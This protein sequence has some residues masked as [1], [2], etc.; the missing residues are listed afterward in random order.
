MTLKKPSFG[1]DIPLKIKFNKHII[2]LGYIEGL[3]YFIDALRRESDAPIVICD[4]KKNIESLKIII[5]K[6]DYVYHYVDDPKNANTL[7]NLNISK[8]KHVLIVS[9]LRGDNEV[10]DVDAILLASYIQEWYPNIKTTVEFKNEG[11]IMMIESTLFSSQ[12]IDVTKLFTNSFMTG[13][14]FN[15]SMF[16]DIG[17]KLHSNPFQLKFINDLLFNVRDESNLL[18]IKVNEF[19][20]KLDF[21]IY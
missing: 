19:L 11:S 13:K 15:S 10:L 9:K 17:S 12:Y 1:M 16:L 6:Y 8:A 20:G 18:T 5:N 7:V 21:M 2:I 4:T 14:V 3:D